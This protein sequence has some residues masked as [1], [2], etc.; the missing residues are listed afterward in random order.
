MKPAPGGFANQPF[1]PKA[2][3]HRSSHAIALDIRERLKDFSLPAGTALKVVEVPPGPPVLATLLAE[4]YGADK[5]H[6]A[7]GC[8]QSA[9]SFRRQ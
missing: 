1:E 8:E 9:R 2:E 3:R 6:A 7:R 4:I 5:R